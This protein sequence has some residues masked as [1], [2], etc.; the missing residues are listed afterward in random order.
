VGGGEWLGA[1]ML[2]LEVLF[3]SKMKDRS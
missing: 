1:Q 2:W 3:G